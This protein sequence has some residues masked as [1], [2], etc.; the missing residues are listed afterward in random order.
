MLKNKYKDLQKINS[1]I[2]DNINNNMKFQGMKKISNIE[3]IKIPEKMQ[4]KIY[5]N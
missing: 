1:N 3:G 4:K 2:K 5:L